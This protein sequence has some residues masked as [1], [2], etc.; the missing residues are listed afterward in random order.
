MRQERI[1][2]DEG[3]LIRNSV[4]TS[5]LIDDLSMSSLLTPFSR[6]IK[7]FQLFLEDLIK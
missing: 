3:V 2:E 4:T 5:A 6:Q 1:V 7:P